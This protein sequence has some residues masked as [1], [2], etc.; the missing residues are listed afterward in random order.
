[1]EKAKGFRAAFRELD[2]ATLQKRIVRS[3]VATRIGIGLIGVLFPLLLLVGGLLVGICP[4][5]SMSAYY[6][7]AGAAGHSMRNWFVGLL[8]MVSISLGLYRG[9]SKAEDILL[10]VAAVFGVGIALFPMDWDPAKIKCGAIGPAVIAG[11][12]FAGISVHGI[13]AV[14]FFLCTAIVCWF[15]ADDTLSLINNEARQKRLRIIYRTIGIFMPSSMLVAWAVNTLAKT[16]WAQF[17]TEAAGIFAFGAFWLVK[18]KEL[19]DTAAD[20]KAAS[21]HIRLYA[22]HLEEIP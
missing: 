12:G 9:F 5:N 17:W 10:D 4:Q 15:C 21:G 16:T 14:T 11:P 18:S 2:A 3:Y 22:G 7:A 13:C 6:Y 19:S 1:M 20:V 8:F